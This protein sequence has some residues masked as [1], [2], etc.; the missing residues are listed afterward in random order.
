MNA[1]EFL[2]FVFE[3]HHGEVEPINER[4]LIMT[5]DTQYEKEKKDELTEA[6]IQF[7]RYKLK[8]C[9]SDICEAFGW[10]PL[11]H[12]NREEASKLISKILSK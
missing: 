10:E 4:R 5:R 7:V 8:E 12:Y 11:L 3:K 1:I 9:I 6:Q 2:H